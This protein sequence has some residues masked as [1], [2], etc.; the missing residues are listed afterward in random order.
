MYVCMY[1]KFALHA[2]IH[3]KFKM[4]VCMYVC[5]HVK[6]SLCMLN[7]FKAGQKRNCSR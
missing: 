2:Y 1:V 3:V 4:Y 5:M 6:C 7:L